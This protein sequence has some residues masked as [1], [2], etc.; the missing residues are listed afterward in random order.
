M[1][2][3]SAQR[4]GFIGQYSVSNVNEYAENADNNPFHLLKSS[5]AFCYD[6]ERIICTSYPLDLDISL[7]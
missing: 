1:E 6:Y 2:R 4:G 5:N 3:N 7:P